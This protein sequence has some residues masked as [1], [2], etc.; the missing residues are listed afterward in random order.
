MKSSNTLVTKQNK[1]KNKTQNTKQNK[2]KTKRKQTPA[3]NSSIFLYITRKNQQILWG[4]IEK[5]TKPN[6]KRTYVSDK[7]YT[8]WKF[9][10]TLEI[11]IFSIYDISLCSWDIKICLNVNITMTSHY[12]MLIDKSFISLPW[13]HKITRGFACLVSWDTSTHMNSFKW[14]RY[15]ISKIHKRFQYVVKQCDVIV[16][17]ILIS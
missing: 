15:I 14:F 4:V 6:Q 9:Q 8:Q 16:M 11:V 1:T 10:R 2:T 17:Q 13:S 7:V 3:R 12:M 5:Q